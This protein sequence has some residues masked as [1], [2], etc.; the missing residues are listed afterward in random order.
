[1]AFEKGWLGIIPPKKLFE[2]LELELSKVFSNLFRKF[3]KLQHN[4]QNRRNRKTICRSIHT[5]LH[6][7]TIH[8]LGVGDIFENIAKGTTDPRVEFSLQK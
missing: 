6:Q 5:Q 2:V 8:N 3:P 7:S 1:M 4:T